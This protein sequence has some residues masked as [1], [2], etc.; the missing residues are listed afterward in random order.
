L[1]ASLPPKNNAL[2]SFLERLSK[3]ILPKLGATTMSLIKVA[4]MARPVPALPK[5]ERKTVVVLGNGPSLKKSLL[6]SER[7]LSDKD[8][9]AVNNL[10]TS[11]LYTLA[12]PRYYTILDPNYW[13]TIEKYGLRELVEALVTKTSWPMTL[14]VPRHAM[15]APILLSIPKSNPNIKLQPFNY[16]PYRGSS[17]IGHWLYDR[18][19]AA[20]Q[21]ENVLMAALTLALRMRYAE[22]VIL[23][24]EHSWHQQLSL[25]ADNRI[26]L[27]H[28]HFSEND[29]VNTTPPKPLMKSATE[30]FSMADVFESFGRVFRGYEAMAKYAKHLDSKVFNATPGS[31]ID[32]FPRMALPLDAKE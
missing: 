32:V 24:A 1:R 31:Y 17:G 11:E 20:P 2:P 22:V 14:F 8:C 6:A 5:A 30:P 26:Y 9:F 7:W 25:D 19:L 27:K 4:V 10:A 18:G 3:E 16:V 13:R 21:S 28:L 12:K 15:Q 29:P 23:G